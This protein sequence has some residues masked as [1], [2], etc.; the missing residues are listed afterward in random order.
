VLTEIGHCSPK[1]SKSYGNLQHAL[2]DF[3]SRQRELPLA[4]SAL[5]RDQRALEEGRTG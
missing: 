1:G 2:E 5:R 4:L 3:G